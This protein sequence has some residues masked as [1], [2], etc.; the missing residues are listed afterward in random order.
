MKKCFKCNATK[1]ISDFYVHLQ[2]ADGHLNKCKECT[3]SDVA[4]RAAE[5]PDQIK[6]YERLRNTLPGRR[7]L[8]KSYASEYRSK[9]RDKHLARI[10]VGNA[11]RGKKLVKLPCEICGNSKSEAHH[12]DYSK[13]LEVKWVCK[14]HHM[15]LHKESTL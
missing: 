1:D 7:V 8:K 5:K 15:Q 13:P 10:K 6:A 9:N 3:K 4:K 12:H 14:F 11:L 2:M